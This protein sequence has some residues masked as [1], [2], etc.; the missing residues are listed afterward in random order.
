[1]KNLFWTLG[2]VILIAL[3]WYVPRMNRI[4]SFSH[5]ALTSGAVGMQIPGLNGS[6]QYTLNGGPKRFSKP[7]QVI[8][9]NVGD[10][11]ELFD[12][13]GKRVIEPKE[14]MKIVFPDK[15]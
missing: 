2:C 4:L 7:G 12:G 14:K 6:C 11:L 3:A 13:K 15:K 10:R 5:S 1:M 8:E 9:L